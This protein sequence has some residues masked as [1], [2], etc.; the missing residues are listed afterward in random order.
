M[1]EGDEVRSTTG[2]QVTASN[3]SDVISNKI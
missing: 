3:C 1:K 2:I